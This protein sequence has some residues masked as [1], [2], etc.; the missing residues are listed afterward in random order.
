M[1]V[2]IQLDLKNIYYIPDEQI[3]HTVYNEGHH[4]SYSKS[5]HIIYVHYITSSEVSD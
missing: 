3:R 1:N 5:Y 4:M 2:I